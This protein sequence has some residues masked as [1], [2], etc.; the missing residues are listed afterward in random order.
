MVYVPGSTVVLTETVTPLSLRTIFELAPATGVKSDRWI[1]GAVEIDAGPACAVRP[2][3]VEMTTNV[4]TNSDKDNF[5][6]IISSL[7]FSADWRDLIGIP[8]SDRLNTGLPMPRPPVG[9]YF[10]V[11]NVMYHTVQL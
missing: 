4:P 3:S 1:T 5:L 8:G 2:D 11:T 7:L 9:F 10:R 6:N